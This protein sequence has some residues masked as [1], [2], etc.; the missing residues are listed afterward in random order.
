M[1]GASLGTH[2]GGGEG[3]RWASWRL[4]GLQPLPYLF[5]SFFTLWLRC[6]RHGLRGGVT[7]AASAARADGDGRPFF[8]S[9][10]P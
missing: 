3:R 10:L 9:S 5:A 6:L 4:S 2:V 1:G 7:C 8:S